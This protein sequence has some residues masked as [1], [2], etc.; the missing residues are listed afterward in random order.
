MT[1]RTN[2]SLSDDVAASLDRKLDTEKW[3]KGNRSQLVNEIL[4]KYFER[5][6]LLPKSGEPENK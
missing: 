6:G 4:Y 2:L 1:V 5:E 3:R